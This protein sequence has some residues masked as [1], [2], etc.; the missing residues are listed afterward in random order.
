[1]LAVLRFKTEENNTTYSKAVNAD[2]TLVI[3]YRPDCSRCRRVLPVLYLK[4]SMSRKREFILN[5]KYLTPE[6]KSNLEESSTPTFRYKG[7]V[8]ATDDENKIERIWRISH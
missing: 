2:S 6:Q 1:M 8:W 3:I 5:A 4:H 7:K